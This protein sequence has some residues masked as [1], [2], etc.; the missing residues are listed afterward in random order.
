[1]KLYEFQGKEI[2]R[3]AGI[4]VP[5]GF[6][7]NSTQEVDERP[8]AFKLPVILKAQVLAGRRGKAG[9]IQKQNNWVQIRDTVDEWIGKEFNGEKIQTVLIERPLNIARELY[10]AVTVDSAAG[11]PLMMACGEGGM[12]IEELSATRPEAIVKERIN[13]FRGPMS[14]QVRNMVSAIGLKED[15]A[16][17]AIKVFYI[18]YQ[19]FRSYDAELVEI[20]P[21]VVDDRGGLW[22]ADAKFRID[23]NALFRH[24]EFQRGREQ[25]D[26]ELEYE[27]YQDGLSY[28]ALDGNIGVI[29][30]GAGLTMTTLDLVKLNGGRP[31]NFLDF[32]G[33][34]YR[35][36]A[37][38]LR[39]AL[40]IPGL[41]VLLLVTFGLFARADTIAEGVVEA[42]REIKPDIPIIMA[43]RGTGEER[44]REMI[45]A[46]GIETYNDTEGAVQKAIQLAEG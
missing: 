8:E 17:A 22:A 26:D 18:V 40:K 9:L 27:A 31:A 39:T 4:P 28:V 1:M 41:K 12:E 44:A 25:F 29:C 45:E 6:L 10:V 46:I 33:A 37:N 21:L 38:A 3:N 15:T 14:Y 42:V 13:I 34:N 2:F 16:K 24:K 35:N 19:L 11:C 20:N 5:E 32:G 23:D 36:A 7:V 43:V 30:T